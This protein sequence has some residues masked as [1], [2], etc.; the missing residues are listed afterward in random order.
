MNAMTILL[1][2]VTVVAIELGF[3]ISKLQST[4]DSIIEQL[5]TANESLASLLA[6]TE[7]EQHD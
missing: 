4:L 5:E 1:T 6:V 7:S 2:L 3:G